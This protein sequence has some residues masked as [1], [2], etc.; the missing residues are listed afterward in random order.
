MKNDHPFYVYV[1][2]DPRNFEEFYYGKGQGSRKLS[3]LGDQ[4][5]SPKVARIQEIRSAGLDPIIKVVAA[6]LT[7]A[8]AHLIETTLIWKLGRGLTNLAAGH[9]ASRFRPH[10]TLHRDLSG[11]DYL[12]GLYYFNVGEGPHRNWNDCRRLG[13]VSAGQGPRWRDQI[14]EFNEGDLI[15]AYLKGSGFVGVGRILEKAVRYLD[16]RINQKPLHDLGLVEPR[17][18]ENSDHPD[19]SEYVARVKWI[20]SV[21]REEARW[22]PKSGLFTS[23]LVRA[24]LDNQPETIAF[25]DNEFGVDLKNLAT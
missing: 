14:C 22:R 15:A 7:E 6:N 8:E 1:Y 24:S 16:F 17:M 4:S 9:H 18:D 12:H 11:F 25:L 20:A 10:N 23:Q 2:I 13:F 5:D 21:P 19:L 3:H